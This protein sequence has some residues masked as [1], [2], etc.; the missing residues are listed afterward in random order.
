V[1]NKPKPKPIAKEVKKE[2]E[3]KEGDKEEKSAQDQMDEDVPPLEETDDKKM[4][5][6]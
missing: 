5:L 3:K 1:I 6:D 2:N 4:D